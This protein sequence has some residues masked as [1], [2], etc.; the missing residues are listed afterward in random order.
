MIEYIISSYY[1][2]NGHTYLTNNNKNHDL[3]ESS[4]SKYTL[5]HSTHTHTHIYIYTHTNKHT[6]LPGSPY[7]CIY[8]PYTRAC[9]HATN[10]ICVYAC[11]QGTHTHT[12]ACLH[13]GHRAHVCMQEHTARAQAG[14]KKHLKRMVGDFK[15]STTT[16]PY[17]YYYDFCHYYYVVPPPP[18]P[19]LLPISIRFNHY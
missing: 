4:A 5:C 12:H 15:T 19:L 7:L 18:P 3:E 10:N 17:Y 16:V 1:I 8:T 14:N 9:M 11:M 2:F 6:C 13:T